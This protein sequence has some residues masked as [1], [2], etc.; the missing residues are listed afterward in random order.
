MKLYLQ[1]LVFIIT[2]QCYAQKTI[3]GNFSPA[4]DYSWLIVYKLWPEGQNYIADTRIADGKFSLNLPKNSPP[5]TYRL[6]YAVPQEEFYFDVIYNGEE[7]ISLDFNANSG[8]TFISSRENILFNDYFKDIRLIEQQIVAFYASEKQDKKYFRELS[9]QLSLTQKKYEIDSEGLLANIFIRSNTPYIPSKFEPLDEFVEHRKE[10]YF[11]ELELENPELQ[12]SGFLTDKLINYVFTAIPLQ[13]IDQASLQQLVSENVQ[14][15]ATHLK[16]VDPGYKLNLFRT[17]WDDMVAN[18]FEIASDYLFNDHIKSLAKEMGNTEIIKNI[19]THNRLRIGAKAPEITWSSEDELHQLSTLSKTEKYLLI[20]WSSTCSHCLNELPK[21]HNAL[22]SN[23]NI[24]VLAI[25][26]EDNDI[27]WKKEI[28]KLSEFEHAISL[29]KWESEYAH[30]YDIHQTP[31]Y[32][33]L[34]KDKRIIE[35]P[36]NYEA[37]LKLLNEKSG[38]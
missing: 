7:D 34:D 26:L 36:E 29:G 35:K 16:D 27:S 11:K 14:L 20:F 21:L 33:V 30:L 1:I 4:D 9:R 31:T 12:A 10:Y 18:D 5:G 24:T 3:S 2:L 28:A 19:E 22:L 25:G 23:A 17:L 32:F 13:P 38:P 8:L 15:L 37:L 6:V